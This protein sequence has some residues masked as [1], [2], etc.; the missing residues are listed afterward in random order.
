M[1][2]PAS[3]VR[4]RI[5]RKAERPEDWPGEADDG[6]V[7]EAR[8]AY[9]L[10]DRLEPPLMPIEPP[11]IPERE[12]R[13]PWSD[14]LARVFATDV[15]RCPCG[16]RRKVVAFIPSSRE[17][18]EILERLGINATAPPLP[19]ARVPPRQMEVFDPAP[20]Y[21]GVDVQYPDVA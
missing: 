15:L 6:G 16:G 5:V 12:R 9:K 1:F 20:E 17:A 7:E 19:P 4:P 13:L 18:T 8:I 2:A 14:L 3:K 11:P 10:M 21:D